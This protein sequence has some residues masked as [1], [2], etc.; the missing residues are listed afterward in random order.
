[1]FAA[2]VRWHHYHYHAHKLSSCCSNILNMRRISDHLCEHASLGN[3]QG[4]CLSC[5]LNSYVHTNMSAVAHSG[6][7]HSN[8]V[9][10]LEYWHNFTVYYGIF[11]ISDQCYAL[12][13]GTAVFLLTRSF[14]SLWPGFVELGTEC[15][16]WPLLARRSPLLSLASR[17]LVCLT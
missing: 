7:V 12:I 5:G 10:Q 3:V 16:I 15:G 13:H 4:F 1:M 11:D 14:G 6:G 17:L 2:R 8:E 9:C